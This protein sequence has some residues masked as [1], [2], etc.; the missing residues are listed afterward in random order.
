MNILTVDLE[1]W[2]HIDFD[3]DFLIGAN[4]FDKH[5]VRIKENLKK[6]LALFSAKDVKATF[7]CLGVIAKK[8][9]ELIREI[10]AEGHDIGCHSNSHMLVSN[11]N[12]DEFQKDTH[13]AL[14][15]ISNI[16]GQAVKSYRA[17]CFSINQDCSWAF[18]ILFSN[19]I[20]IDCS[21]FPTN[22]ENG[23]YNGMPNAESFLIQTEAG[24]ELIE[25]P[26]N[27]LNFFGK[28]LCYSGGGYFRLLPYVI[29]K[30]LFKKSNYNMF[31][32]HPRDLDPEQPILEG[33]TLSRRFKSY[34]GLSECEKKLARLLNDFSFVSVK[35]ASMNFDRDKALFYQI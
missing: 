33:L 4:K 25:F 16:T 5:E 20:E 18:D 3:K 23:G 13:E 17:P 29:I 32:I 14:D 2:F 24:S 10:F 21:I 7:F 1:E 8:H 35:H 34:Y 30:K 27:L 26:V 31:Y 6:L 9:P 12:P 19:G 11:M 28:K 22:R 15:V